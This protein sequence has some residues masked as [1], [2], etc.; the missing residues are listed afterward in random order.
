MVHYHTYIRF[1]HSCDIFTANTSFREDSRDL[2]WS[3]TVILRM[4]VKHGLSVMLVPAP[5]NLEAWHIAKSRFVRRRSGS[6][7]CGHVLYNDV[8]SCSSYSTHFHSHFVRRRKPQH[9]VLFDPYGY[10]FSGHTGL[11]TGRTWRANLQNTPIGFRV[12]KITER[13]GIRPLAR[14]ASHRP[15]L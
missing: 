13:S 11:T 2:Q 10:H 7:A 15:A 12:N 1:N 3:L 6:V 4:P 5:L 8:C 14:E 9:S